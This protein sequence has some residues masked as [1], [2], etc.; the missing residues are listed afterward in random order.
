MKRF[1]MLAL[2]VTL[3]V[4][5]LAGNVNVVVNGKTVPVPAT[6]VNGKTFVDLAALAK[7]LDGASYDAKAHKLVL[8]GSSGATGTAQLAGDNG[9]L[10]KLYA[11]RKGDPLYFTLAKAEFTVNPVRI[12]D[13]LLSAKADEK[14]LV[15]RFT[16]QN[17]NKTDRL[18]RFDSLRFMVVDAQNVNHQCRAQWGDALTSQQ[19]GLLLKPAQKLEMYTAIPVPAAGEIPKLMVQSNV[20]NDGPVLRYDLRG[21][22]VALPAPI[23]DPA[24][25]TG[26]TALKEVPAQMNTSYGLDEF[27]VTMEKSEFVTTAL[28]AGP[29]SNGGRYL[30]V[31]LLVKNLLTRDNLLRWDAFRLAL[32][33]A[34]GETL[35]YR[36]TLMATANRPFSSQVKP[37]GEVRVRLYF[38]VPNDAVPQSLTI[39]QRDSHKYVFPIGK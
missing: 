34:D 26:A 36:T 3:G 19:V 13:T 1:L 17:P 27:A 39:S 14:L 16:V 28:D 29:P 6:V 9:E 24:D 37:D 11:M 38:E 7:L 22:V 10:G 31:T 5:A 30:V 32:V 8:A 15:L 33:S 25:A 2:L 23:A 21:K 12:G 4:T 18:V 35:R 20:D